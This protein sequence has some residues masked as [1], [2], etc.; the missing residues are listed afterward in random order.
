MEKTEQAFLNHDK[1]YPALLHAEELL[2]QK[3]DVL[4]DQVENENAM[5]FLGGDYVG[6]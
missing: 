1:N 5:Q 3:V 6:N 2:K 4:C